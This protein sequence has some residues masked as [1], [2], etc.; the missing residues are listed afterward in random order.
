M[1]DVRKISSGQRFHLLSRAATEHA[2][3]VLDPDGYIVE[4]SVGAQQLLGW[5][6]EE[7]VD[8]PVAIIFTAEDQAVGVPQSELQTARSRGRAADIRWY[9]RKGGSRFQADGMTYSLY[10]QD[11][12]HLG[13]GK[14]LRKA[15]VA[16]G[17]RTTER[18]PEFA[19]ERE[20]LADSPLHEIPSQAKARVAVEHSAQERA[21]REPTEKNAN[22]P[23]LSEERFRSLVMAAAQ[24]VW[25]A[26]ADGRISEDSPTWRAFTGQTYGQLKGFGW[27]DPIHPDDRQRCIR[28]WA[29]S[30]NNATAYQTEYRLRRRDGVYRWVMARGVPVRA[31]DGGIREWVGINVDVS[32]VKQIAEALHQSEQQA[33]EAA[34]QAQ[35]ERR[36]LDAVLNAAPVGI[37][38]ADASGA[39]LEVNPANRRLLGGSQPLSQS[40]DEY[41]EWRGWWADGSGSHGRAIEPHEWPLA[42]ALRGEET[43]QNTIE[44]ETFGA[45]PVRRTV[46]ASGAPIKG[47]KGEITGGVI[48][49]MDLTDRVKAEASLREAAERLQF[50]LASAQIG[51]WDLDLVTGTEHRS[52]RHDQCFGYTEPV[53]HWGLAEFLRHVHPEDRER[54]R[55]EFEAALRELGD[56]HLEFRVTWPDRSVHWIAAHGSVQGIQ[57]KPTRMAGIVFEVTERKQA[58]ERVR[59]ASLHDALTGLPNRAMLFE[60]AS[61]LLPHNRRTNQCA[62]V[63]LIDLDRFKPINDTHGHEIGDAVLKEVADRLTR[64]LEDEDLVIRLGGDEFLILLQDMRSTVYAAEVAGRVIESINEPYRFGELALSLSAS[65]GIS[66]FPGDGRDIDALINHASM[67]MHQAKQLGRNNFQFYSQEFAAGMRLTLAIEQR[68]KSALTNDDFHLCYQPVL[69]VETDEVVSVEA[70]LRWRDT[71]IGPD[72]FVPVA[73]ATGMIN[74]MGR[75]SLEEASQQHKSWL[76]HGLPPIPIA[77]NVSV[78]EFRDRNF[79]AHF[80][81]TLQRYGIDTKAVQLELTETAVMDDIE[82]A[83]ATLSQLKAMGVTILLDDFG[84]GHSS[85]AYLARLPLDKV[86]IDKSFISRLDTDAASRTVTE[87]MIALARALNLDV[88]A[89]GVESAAVLDYIRSR[90]CRQGQGFYLGKP[91]SGAAFESWYRKHQTRFR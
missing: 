21:R 14:M 83:V 51:D 27:L 7:A 43:P 24:I 31:D 37:M 38:V 46:L 5:S 62:A 41:R 3:I 15:H 28:A 91:M 64:T 33:L 44:I 55:R 40:I 19:A 10:D 59:H 76:E 60:Y 88:V 8:Q 53:P 1:T 48:A 9:V 13:F 58:E 26:N 16:L 86:K 89:E 45:Q 82:H 75:W 90:G 54:V 25:T 30:I 36:R 61:R 35:A 52:L 11:G 4:W 80:E 74:P 32:D 67:A 79:V 87:A 42:R 70:L 18:R 69:D 49:V 47:S 56:W 73:E 68:L 23:R 39:L 2:I 84:T 71:E 78:V 12:T 17:L 34:R 66:I 72:Q 57:G 85:L 50:I 6:A 77:V 20:F 22:H 63:L 81:R 65:I 29:D